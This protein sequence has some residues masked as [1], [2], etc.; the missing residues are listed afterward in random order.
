[1]NELTV[2]GS[3]NFM[4]IEIPVVAGGF[5]K[6]KRC[7]SDKTIA[8]IHDIKTRHVRER[9]NLNIKRF[10]KSVDFIDLISGVG[11]NDTSELLLDLGYTRQ[12]ILQAEHI[13]ILSD[14]GYAKLIKIMDSDLAWEIHDK[15]IDEYFTLKEEKRER[16]R[17]ERLA[18]VNNAVKILTPMLEKAGCNSQIQLLTAKSLYEKAGVMIPIEIQAD[19]RYW[20]TVHIARQA[21]VYYKT[22]GKPSDKAVN[23]IIRRIGVSDG[24]YTDTWEAKGNW[25]GTVRKYSDEVIDRVKC[26]LADNDYPDKIQ[27]VQSN[28]EKKYYHVVYKNRDAA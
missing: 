14:R 16:I 9:I 20:D 22:S 10:K 15:L 17:A 24:D 6:D 5:G 26:W 23:E 27:Y 1:M 13:Y 3:Q 28:G 25:E 11:E 8:E 12:E 4:G 18:S 19:K 7:M 2:T 21:G